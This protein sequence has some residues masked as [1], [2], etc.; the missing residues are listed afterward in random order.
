MEVVIPGPSQRLE[1]GWS[2][3]ARKPKKKKPPIQQ[4]SGTSRT[5][6]PKARPRPPAPSAKKGPHMRVPN[7]TAVILTLLPAAVEK[8]ISYADVMEKAKANIKLGDLGIAG[9]KLKTARTGARMLLLP[10][11]DSGEK[12][13]ALAARLRA[14]L[15]EQEVKPYYVPPRSD[16][17]GD[18]DGSVAIIVRTA[19]ACPP[20]A[21]VVKGQG[22]VAA[23]I[24][25]MV[26]LGGY[27]SPNRRLADFEG[28]IEEVG[29]VVARSRPRP[30]LVLGDFNAK[31]VA[32]GSPR[33]CA[34]GEALEEWAIEKGLVVLNRGSVHTCV[35]QQG[36]S[37][38]DVTFA[39]PELARRVR[40]WRVVTG[41]ETL[42]DH[43]YIRFSVSAR[44][45]NPPS[46][47]SP[48]GDCPRWALQKLNRE[49]F[50][51]ALIVATWASGSEMNPPDVN[52]EQ[53]ADNLRSLVT[54]V[55]DAAMPRRGRFQPF[56]KVYWWNPVLEGLRRALFG[57]CLEQGQ[58]P[59]R[60]K[61]GKLV[62]LR[63]EGRPADSPSAYRPI[64]LL[65]EVGK[66][67][68][69]IIVDRLVQ[70]LSTTGPDLADNQFGLAEEAVSRGEV[71]LAVSLDIANAFNSL[72]WPC[73]MEAL[74]Y[75]G[76]PAYLRRI[77]GAY[78]NSRAVIYPVHE[79]WNRRAMVCG[80]PQGS[81]LG[82]LLWNIAYDWTL[83]CRVL[84]GVSVVC[85]ADDT[86]IAA[87]GRTHRQACLLGT[88]G[89]STIVGRIRRLG[90]EV[91][92][93]KTEAVMFHGPR[94]RPPPDSCITV[95]GIRIGIGGTMKYLGLVLD[96]RW[97][98][99]AHFRQLL[100]RLK[101]A[102]GALSRLLPNVGGPNATCRKLFEGIVRSMALYGAPVWSDRLTGK[103]A[104][105]LR[106]AQRILAVRAIRGYRTVS[107]EVASLLAGSP[108]WDLEARVLASLY[109]WRKEALARGTRPAPREIEACR[110]EL[111]QVAVGVWEERLRRPSAGPAT[112]E[113]VR[114]VLQEWI[115]RRHGTLTFRLTQVLTGH[116]CFGRYLCR[117]GREATSGCHHCDTGD[118]DTALHT[119]RECPAWTEQRRE[120]VA[121]TGF[122]TSLPAVVRTM[123]G[124]STGW[125]AVSSFCEQ[126]MFAKEEA[127]RERERNS[128]LRSRQ[129]RTRRRRRSDSDLR[130][131]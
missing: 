128:L 86:L 87:R 43:R 95:G 107:F 45:P 96:S 117:L 73:I 27:F 89:V 41:V 31:S 80:V 70:H 49:V 16:W 75:F 10:G 54:G 11:K 33:T 81:V 98:F 8:G 104:A 118:E 18:L 99:S 127:E 57:A 106:Q 2:V 101:G 125:D 113:A 21:G 61:T 35:R 62:L 32:W 4:Q 84:P 13:D 130:P 88:A 83:R 3:V 112:I 114:P 123:V 115:G 63:K 58:F 25:E 59:Q 93:Q 109:V 100:P 22:Y 74:R 24:G 30:V 90:L 17:A 82:P 85:Y 19:A 105:L 37:I 20:L 94:N 15:P 48:V 67:F 111:R 97:D 116:G 77:V 28:W 65:D 79:G 6:Q 66:L 110:S 39:S 34:R 9:V 55:C 5:P 122:D 131:P 1:E 36:G 50:R 71:L 120:L 103:N 129:R 53:E 91:A 14:V 76:V 38:V 46:R 23:T 124:S 26:V 42:S 56:R 126:V 51:E 7:T 119:L 78:L 12:A 47:E 121:H 44:N 72:P 69:R 64:V 60:W 29:T 108:P 52:V 92:L 40:D 102:A 68:E